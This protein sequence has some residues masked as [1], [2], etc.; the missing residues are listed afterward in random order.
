MTVFSGEDHAVSG[1]LDGKV[2]VVTGAAHGVGSAI[3]RRFL[4]AGARVMICDEDEEALAA[5]GDSF[6]SEHEGRWVSFCCNLGGKLGVANLLAATVDAFD[7]FDILVNAA[8]TVVL[9][10]A[11]N[12]TAETLDLSHQLNLRTP[13]V[14]SQA[15]AKKMI[16]A[17]E[18]G[19]RPSG[20]IVNISSI[21]ARRTAP[22][23][24]PYSIACAAL[25]QMTR[26][27]AVSLAP[28]GV[29]VNGV[30][31]GGVMTRGLKAALKER[32]DLRAELTSVTPL[33]RVGEADEI[34]EAALFLA[35]DR[36]GFVTGQILVVDGGRTLLDPLSQPAH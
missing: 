25:D 19:E 18:E 26:S 2:A 24:L 29:R 28:H 27:M 9:G 10:D 23:M 6:K 30:A 20:A 1:D 35:S 11:L 17:V 22:E 3:A 14:L 21:A 33:G 16:G 12:T 8:R 4:E 36:A 13:F 31:L 15:A 34:A 7:R 5:V 32:A